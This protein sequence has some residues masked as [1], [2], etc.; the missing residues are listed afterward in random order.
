MAKGY[1]PNKDYS[2]ELQRNDLTSSERA[3]LEQERQNKIDD[4]YGGKEPNM[5]GSNNKFSDIYHGGGS[6]GRDDRDDPG[7]RLNYGGFDYTE[8]KGGLFGVPTIN[9]DIKNYTQ[10]GIKYQVGANMSRRPDLAGKVAISNGYTVFYDRDGY[11]TKAVKGTA[12]Y[13]PHMDPHVGVDGKYN[14]YG[15]WTDQEILTP[16]DRKR[17]EE[18]RA[19]I[20]TKY[21][22][23]E[24]NRLANQIRRGYGYTIDKGGNVTDLRAL[25]AVEAF[26]DR[27]GLGTTPPTED[28]QA[29]LDIWYNN[30]GRPNVDLNGNPIGP[31]GMNGILGQLGAGFGG[32]APEYEGSKWDP[33]LD[34]LAQQLMDMNYEDWTRGDQYAALAER[35]GQQ[36]RMSMQDVLGQIASRTG[37]LASSYAT[38]A[39]QQSYN[40]L[41]SQL[42]QAAMEMYGAERQDFWKRPRWHSKTP[43]TT[44][45]SGR[46]ALPSGTRTAISSTAYIGIRSATSGMKTNGTIPESSRNRRT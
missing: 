46:T 14:A 3:Q 37:G 8:G 40:D 9:S 10:S 15:S 16:E 33:I 20:G 22:G 11:A 29:F 21:T 5:T 7:G 25:S 6:S 12:D 18:I 34:E 2:K 39:A 35:Y 44:M 43:R 28:Q 19:G 1:D 45:L 32:S 24:A 31:G 27:L 23:D 13:S 36:G 17:I 41:M 30:G 42:E 38:S 26:R 4:K